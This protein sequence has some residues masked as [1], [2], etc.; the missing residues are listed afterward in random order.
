MSDNPVW[1][2]RRA[3][4]LAEKGQVLPNPRV[5]AVLVKDGEKIGEG[6]HAQYGG[7]HAEI[8]ALKNCSSSPK[9]ATLYVTLEPCCHQGKTPPCTKAI[10]AAGISKVVVAVQDHSSKVNG[11][12]LA[13]LQKA[14][15]EVE[16]GLMEEEAR[17][18]NK[19]FFAFHEKGRPFITLKWAQSLDA[20]IG[21]T[22][23][24]VLLSGEPALN[25]AHGLRASHQA[26]LVGASTA[27][28][29]DPQLTTRRV[30]G[31]DPLRIVLQGKKKLPKSL[32]IFANKNHLILPH[33]DLNQTL[34]TLTE[35]GIQSVLV[36]GGAQ[37][38]Q[39][40]LDAGLWDEA[41]VIVAPK[42]LGEGA[43]NAPL[44]P[45][46]LAAGKPQILGKDVVWKMR[47][48]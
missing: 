33:Q 25:F 47:K 27:L 8:E 10:I 43:V 26:I 19:A 34:Q 28:N 6:Y 35:K 38:L 18:L 20:K 22:D 39:S 36:E 9:G 30:P 7:N 2:M 44:L 15:I 24:K 32:K 14:G 16:V 11:K 21:I 42:T 37:V 3:L 29:D 46:N 41:F 5:G 48:D 23:Q 1:H 17:R 31:A 40:F 45:Q 12:G 4:K 13:E